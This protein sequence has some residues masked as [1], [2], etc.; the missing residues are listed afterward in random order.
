[1]ARQVGSE[2]VILDL[3][4][5]LYFGLDEVGTRVWEL[6]GTGRSVAAV[7]DELHAEY[8]APIERLRHDVDAL[9]ADLQGRG[10]LVPG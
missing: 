6:L 3:A 1:M 10:L 2:T 7:C 8:D 5:G 9:V 4:S